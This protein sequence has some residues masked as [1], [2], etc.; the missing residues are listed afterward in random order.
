M[1]HGDIV[2]LYFE[3]LANRTHTPYGQDA[4]YYN[5]KAGGTYRNHHVLNWQGVCSCHML[6]RGLI[7][8]YND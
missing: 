5:G 1:V 6:Y 4:E 8:S 7:I 2:T 3:Y